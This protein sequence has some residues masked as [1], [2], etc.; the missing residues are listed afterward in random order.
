M[1]WQLRSIKNNLKEILYKITNNY[2]LLENSKKI[3][4]L[5]FHMLSLESHRQMLKEATGIIS[6]EIRDLRNNY[7]KHLVQKYIQ[8]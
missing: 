3:N 1:G 7:T 5:R 4:L 2:F 6:G 8:F